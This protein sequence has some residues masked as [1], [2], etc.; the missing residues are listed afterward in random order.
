MQN[1]YIISEVASRPFL[2]TKKFSKFHIE[3]FEQILQ[4]KTNRD[5][6]K[7]YGYSQRSHAVVD[8]SRRVMYKLLAMEGLSRKDYLEEVI[9]PRRFCFWWNKLLTQHHHALVNNAIDP[10]YYQPTQQAWS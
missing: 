4:G 1:I 3:L 6:N 9:F 2:K 7:I 8:H 5:I 10:Q